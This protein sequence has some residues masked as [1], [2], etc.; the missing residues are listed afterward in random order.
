[1][2]IE[3]RTGIEILGIAGVI[4][5]LVFVG[6]Q[7]SLD[8]KVALAEQ[9]ANRAESIKSDHRSRLES[10]RYWRTQLEKWE[11]GVRPSWWSEELE[12]YREE[13]N[14][15]FDQMIEFILRLQLI[16]T[17]TDNLY[18]QYN[19]G[20]YPPDLWQVNLENMKQA[21]NGNPITREF[22]MSEP[23]SMVEVV[24]SMIEEFE[25]D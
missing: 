12:K 4:G 9:Y 19:Q 14:I 10:E 16:N 15:S 17:H 24:N 2:K 6:L 5:S 3:L 22:I 21:F 8:R 23:R 11:S 13:E 20:L 18:Y 7:L 1:V 25:S